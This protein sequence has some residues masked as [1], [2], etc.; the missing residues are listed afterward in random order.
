MLFPPAAFMQGT[1]G[2]KGTCEASGPTSFQNVVALLSVLC[3]RSVGNE[4]D[5]FIDWLGLF[6]WL[7]DWLIFC[8]FIYLCVHFIP[9]FPNLF[10]CSLTHLFCFWYVYWSFSFFI[11]SIDSLF[12]RCAV[13]DD[14]EQ[15]SSHG[16]V[17]ISYQ[18][19]SKPIILTIRDRLKQNGLNVWVDVDNMSVYY[20]T[21]HFVFYFFSQFS[22]ID[23]KYMVVIGC[24]GAVLSI[25]LFLL[26][27]AYLLCLISECSGIRHK[28]L[29]YPLL[30]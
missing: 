7:I 14:T 1:K 20:S 11:H 16:H 27:T 26:W 10:G 18:W 12:V 3:N 25:L 21:G 8:V 29:Y 2:E 19:D 30:V 15:Q 28:F 24:Y 23:I 6:D 17:F 4:R 9:S 13:K 22:R 5:W